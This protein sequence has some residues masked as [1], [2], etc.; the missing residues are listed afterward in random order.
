M[1][2]G[3]KH[4][5]CS[6]EW[7][8]VARAYVEGQ[9]QGRDL[10]GIRLRFCEK[11]TDAPASLAS[12]P[13]GVTGWYIRIEDG[14]VDVGH[15]LLADAD[16]TITADYATVVPLARTVFEGNPEGTQAAEK[17]VAEATEQGKMKREGDESAMAATPFLAG[18]HDAL[19]KRTA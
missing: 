11:F 1:D 6:E 13:G 16:L 15:G 12:E 14:Q 7:V 18:L 5:F 9:C 10:A 2:T 19:A 17:A 3:E 4:P 8:G